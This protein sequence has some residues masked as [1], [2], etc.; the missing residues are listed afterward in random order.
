MSDDYQE[1]LVNSIE[2]TNDN[3]Q[4]IPYDRACNNSNRKDGMVCFVF[5]N[6]TKCFDPAQI[7]VNEQDM[8]I[9]MSEKAAINRS[10]I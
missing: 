2:Y 9:V 6:K 3:E 1:K 5:G 8:T 7:E 10:L 4:T